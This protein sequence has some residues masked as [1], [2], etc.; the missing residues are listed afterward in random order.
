[1]AGVASPDEVIGKTDEDFHW[2]NLADE[3]R[4]DEQEVMNTGI[5]KKL[6]IAGPS[7]G[8]K[9]AVF[10]ATKYPLYG[11]NG[12]VIGILCTSLDI[13][14]RKRAEQQLKETKNKLEELNA[15]KDQFIENMEHDLRTPS[16]GIMGMTKIL[17]ER[18]T[19]SEKKK[20]LHL[21]SQ[22]SERLLNVLNGIVA[23]DKA[24]AGVLSIVNK[25]FSIKKIV[26]DIF[27]M[28]MPT[29]VTKKL[30]LTVKYDDNIS[31][32]I[33][34][35]EQRIFRILLNLI[36]NAIKFTHRGHVTVYVKMPNIIDKQNAILQLIVEDTGIGIPADKIN[37]IY[38]RFVRGTPANQGIYE[39]L[40]LG[41]SMVKH[42]IEDI[43]GEIDVES[44]LGKGT[45][46]TCTIPIKLPL[47]SNNSIEAKLA[48]TEKTEKTKKAKKVKK[49]KP[50]QRMKTTKAIKKSKIVKTTAEKKSIKSPKS[51]KAVKSN[52][53]GTRVLLVEDD[54]LAQTMAS[55]MI[56]EKLTN[57]LDIADSGEEAIKL[58]DKNKYDLIF[59]D[60][61]L[62][63]TK[64]YDVTRKIRKS[65]TGKNQKTVIVAL[66][67]HVSQKEKKKCFDAQMNC[68]LTKPLTI[69]KIKE[70]LKEL[71][72]GGFTE[73]KI[74][75]TQKPKKSKEASKTKTSKKMSVSSDLLK[76]EGKV[77]DLKLGMEKL[78]C[79]AE[80][81]K[82]TIELFIKLL[83][84]EMPQLVKAKDKGDWK[85]VKDLAHKHRGGSLYCGVPRLQQAFTNLEHYL[86]TDKTELREQLYQQLLDEI[87]KL[88]AAQE[89]A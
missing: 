6:E 23:F 19:D 71:L 40:G 77:I 45:K 60:I 50:K 62:P 51:I 64:G 83:K 5:P 43:E 2:K 34:S 54:I 17:E 85:T 25:K 87:D 78:S 28:E 82:K 21:L 75:E 73:T 12:K 49:V 89:K 74:K 59:M 11:K 81:A 16:S 66:T 53:S 4:K 69:N 27:A 26:S 56:K 35:D 29:V 8:G 46:F 57:N 61:G 39:G 68:F 31:D 55:N 38:K 20:I 41:L 7:V 42:F 79:D 9:P 67:A 80:Q 24:E 72:S 30:K 86:I 58:T 70:V 10:L 47:L 52:K 65:K 33:I 1:M 13:T 76:I 63:N 44:T 37:S 32:M 18:E 48:K 84:E 14:E 22:A 36:G 3:V 88:Y 15:L